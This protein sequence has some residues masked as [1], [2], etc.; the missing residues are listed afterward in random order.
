[1]NNN[2]WLGFWSGI[3]ALIA[4]CFWGFGV[5]VNRKYAFLALAGIVFTA[6]TI[7][8]IDSYIMNLK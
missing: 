8:K 3:I 1:M 7:F 6:I 5:V 2:F 4:V